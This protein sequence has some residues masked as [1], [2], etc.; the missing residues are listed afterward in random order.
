MS[1]VAWPSAIIRHFPRSPGC[2]SGA[3]T[4][5]TTLLGV[6]IGFI[7][8]L[9][10]RTASAQTFPTTAPST[11]A[12]NLVCIGDSIT[13]CHGIPD[14][15]HNSSPAVLAKAL[16]EGLG[17]TVYLVNAGI[18]GTTTAD[19]S[20]PTGLLVRGPRS[21]EALAAK[22][23][24]DHPGAKLVYSIMLGTN[25]SANKGTRGAPISAERYGT[26]MNRIVATLEQD[27][28]DCLIFL[29]H[30]TWYSKNTHNNADYEGDSAHDRLRSY[31]PVLDGIAAA[32][33]KQPKR[34][35]YLGDTLAYDHFAAAYLTELSPQKGK[36]GTFYLHPNQTGAE[37]LGKFWAAPIVAVLKR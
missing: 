28:P 3:S 15:D 17:A 32:D 12:I 33:A 7:A 14:R 16:G 1:T 10:A 29:H 19:W 13:E 20:G 27:H 5:R 23:A 34:H 11:T 24:A 2:T 35:V 22:L 25:D 31:F 26:E 37:S 6:A 4:P 18:S 36:N 30:P 21:A 9:S 8:A